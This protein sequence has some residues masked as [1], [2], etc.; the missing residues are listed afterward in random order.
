MKKYPGT[1]IM[2]LFFLNAASAQTGMSNSLQRL[3]DSTLHAMMHDDSVK[4]DMEFKDKDKWEKLKNVAEYPVLNA[5]EFSGVIPVKGIAEVPDPALEY[6]LLIEL[7][8]NNPDSLAK[9]INN[10]LSEVARIINLHAAAGIPVKNIL[11]VVVVHAGALNAITTNAYYKKHYGTDNPNIK[12][13]GELE[14][15][16]TKFIACGQAMSFISLKKEDLLPQ[17]KVSLTAQTVITSYQ[18]KGY[19]FMPS[20]F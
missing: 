13:V 2:L 12:I 3:K 6:K 20:K 17:V 7:T 8:V 1:L 15:I 16:G 9:E 18:L 19:V 11:P 4:I 10:G 14:K 5:G